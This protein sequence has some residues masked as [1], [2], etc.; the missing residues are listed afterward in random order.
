M[1]SAI[2]E[3]TGS[4]LAIADPIVDSRVDKARPTAKICVNGLSAEYDTTHAR[5]RR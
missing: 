3:C 2:V 4:R 5:A 1:L